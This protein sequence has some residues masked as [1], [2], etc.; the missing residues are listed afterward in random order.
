[1]K[2]LLARA[3]GI[4]PLILCLATL[5]WASNTVASRM[6]V[7]EVSPMMLIFLRWLL[8]SA[9][10]AAL[11]GRGMREAWPVMRSRLGWTLMMGGCGLSLFS[12]LFYVAA[13]TTTA[14]NLGIIQSVIPGFVLLGGF[15]FFGTRIRWLQGLGLGLTCLGVVARGSLAELLSLQFFAGDLLM[16]AACIAYS[17]Y[18]LAL[19]SR[20]EVSLI[21]LM[22]YFS[23]A[24]LLFTI[25]LLA[26]EHATTGITPPST[27]GWLIILYVVIMPSFISQVFFIRGVDLIGPGPAGLYTNTVPVFAAVM[28]ILLLGEEFRPHHV[29]AMLLVFSGI[30]LFG[31]R[32]KTE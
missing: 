3:Y 4:A 25:P 31:I 18:T 19:R 9:L 32:G 5:G 10:I 6:A 30:Y 26:L 12:A 24:A 14:I 17:G 20:P 29:A 15:V 16:L 2:S 27:A 22:G 23:V 13:H 8:V 1:M 21:A 7:G 28:A 11:H